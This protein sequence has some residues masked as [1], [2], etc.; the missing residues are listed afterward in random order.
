MRFTLIYGQ[1]LRFL[2]QNLLKVY[3]FVFLG[4][5]STLIKKHPTFEF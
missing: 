2:K 1:F 3:S 4:I 5:Y